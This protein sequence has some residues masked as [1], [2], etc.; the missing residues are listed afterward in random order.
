MDKETRREGGLLLCSFADFFD[1]RRCGRRSTQ[2]VVNKLRVL[3]KHT[4]QGETSVHPHS[5]EKGEEWRSTYLQ[6]IE[7]STSCI[8]HQ[9]LCDSSIPASKEQFACTHEPVVQIPSTCNERK[10]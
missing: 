9:H 4:K 5:N 3:I 10:I 8:I 2:K 6:R 7:I 1:E